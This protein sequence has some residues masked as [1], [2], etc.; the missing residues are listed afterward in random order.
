M[1]WFRHQYPHTKFT[2]INAAIGGTGSMLGAYRLRHDVL[3]HQ[4]D[5]LFVEFAV[6]DAGAPPDQLTQTMEGIVRHTWLVDPRTDICFVYTLTQQMLPELQSGKFPR[7][8]SVMERVADHYGIPSIHMGVPVARLEQEGQLV[9]TAPKP[10]TSAGQA[11]DAPILFSADGVHPY[12]D[13]GHEVYFQAIQTAFAK[14]PGV[15]KVADHCVCEPLS[16]E[17]WQC[18]SDPDHGRNGGG[19]GLGIIARRPTTGATIRPP[20]ARPLASQPGRR[21]VDSSLSR[22]A[23]RV[24]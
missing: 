10:A 5:L 9:F 6:N 14:L 24:L 16:S 21:L 12:T 18:G 4:P 11:A 17:L 15:G 19:T 20:A 23:R 8:A 1:Q 7:A 2:E 3:R 22:H 13:S